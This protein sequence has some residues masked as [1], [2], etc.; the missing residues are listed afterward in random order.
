MSEKVENAKRLF[1]NGYN[2][3][4][5]VLG[6]FCDDYGL[7]KKTALKLSNGLG[8]GIRNGEVC[9]A[10]SGAVLAIGLKYGFYIEKDIEQKNLCNK[11]AIDFVNA[12]R[13]ENGAILC[14]ELLGV[15]IR[16][17]EDFLTAEAKD[18]V[19]NVCSNMVA[20]AV[21]ILEDMDF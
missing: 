12:F 20:S 14:R 9:G 1:A 21:R 16:A 2:C 18:A 13:K 3:A 19:K 15:D 4:Q 8:G 7:D 6:A 10:V 17:P 5:S 11:K